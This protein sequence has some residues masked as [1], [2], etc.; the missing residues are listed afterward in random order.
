MRETLHFCSASPDRKPRVTAR[1][2]LDPFTKTLEI[3]TVYIVTARKAEITVLL[4]NKECSEYRDNKTTIMPR[5]VKKF[6]EDFVETL[7]KDWPT[8][9]FKEYEILNIKNDYDG[10]HRELH[11][12]KTVMTLRLPPLSQPKWS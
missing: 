12:F 3:E 2:D 9:P 4:D 7:K 8:T 1:L 10:E 11:Y 5:R 6:H